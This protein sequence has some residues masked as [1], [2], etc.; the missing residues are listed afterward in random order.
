MRM[1]K[2]DCGHEDVMLSVA[3][4]LFLTDISEGKRNK[5]K[6]KIFRLREK[7]G[8]SPNC[9]LQSDLFFFMALYNKH[10]NMDMSLGMVER[11]LCPTR[12]T[13]DISRGEL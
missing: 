6:H 13:A 10:R 7:Y 4:S 8:N 12:S 11:V 3:V 2:A 1:V 9:R 5:P